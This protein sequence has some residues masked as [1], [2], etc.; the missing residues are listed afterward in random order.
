VVVTDD[1]VGFDLGEV[2]GDWHFGLS[3]VAERVA[4]AGGEIGLDTGLG[5]GTVVRAVIPAE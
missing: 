3:L 4:A 5:R 2:N 1:G